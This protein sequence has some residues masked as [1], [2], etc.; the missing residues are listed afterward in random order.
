M[1]RRR[2]SDNAVRIATI[3]LAF[4]LL[5][6]VVYFIG[7]YIDILR[8]RWRLATLIPDTAARHK[9]DP[10]L[11]KALIVEESG[12][13]YRARSHK[14]AI[15]LMQV[16]PIVLK[17]YNRVTGRL[18]TEEQLATPE[19]NLEVGC[20]YLAYLLKIYRDQQ[21][22]IYFALAAYNAGP[23]NVER[24]IG[25]AKGLSGPE[26]LKRITFKG[27]RAYVSNILKRWTHFREYE[28]Q[29][30]GD[31]SGGM[32][33]SRMCAHICNQNREGT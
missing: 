5:A 19:F 30:T 12:M 31:G 22:P 7:L 23:S 14:G 2:S 15:G 24:W 25:K 32:T 4:V 20:W 1:P 28:L 13:N 9:L 10:L 3:S 26:F 21:D 18:V 16:M 29:I 6:F 27:T 17:E 8:V 33:P 11:V